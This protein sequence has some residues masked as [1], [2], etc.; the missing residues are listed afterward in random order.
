MAR[1]NRQ[2]ERQKNNFTFTKK[3]EI[4]EIS[5]LKKTLNFSWIP[6]KWSSLLIILLDFVF[7]TVLAIPLLMTRFNEEIALLLGHGVITS[8][9]IVMSFYH[10]EAK[11]KKPTFKE[12]GLR[13]L[14]MAVLL[15]AF[16]IIAILVL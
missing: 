2:V 13:Y 8:L 15:L 3:E 10:L 16:A 12:L 7:V 11:V 6:R 4:K 9:L 14:L 1:F 5:I